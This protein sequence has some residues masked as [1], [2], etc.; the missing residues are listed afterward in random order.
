MLWGDVA[1]GVCRL[2]KASLFDGEF[3]SV[4]IQEL[5][6][7]G[8]ARPLEGR[9]RGGI[10]EG[11]VQAREAEGVG[12]GAMREGYGRGAIGEGYGRGARGEGYGRG[13]RWGAYE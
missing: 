13:A 2:C 12:R 6:V 8:V 9:G 1:E 10:G 5:R 4:E 7:V 11:M 3:R